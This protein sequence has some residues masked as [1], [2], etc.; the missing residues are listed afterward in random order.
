MQMLLAK[1]AVD[2][3]GGKFECNFA[4]PARWKRLTAARRSMARNLQ[5]NCLSKHLATRY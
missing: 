4:I 2:A 1:M 3:G 5:E